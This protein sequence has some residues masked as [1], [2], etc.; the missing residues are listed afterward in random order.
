MF[1]KRSIAG[2]SL[3]IALSAIVAL[4]T[5]PAISSGVITLVVPFSPSSGPDIVAR[6]LA[7]PLG[8]ELGQTVIVENRTGASGEIGMR[9]VARARADGQTLLV[10]ADPPL[11]VNQFLKR[12]A[13]PEPLKQFAPISEL[14]TGTMALVVNNS[15]NV[16]SVKGFV[17]YAKSHA[18]EINYGSPGIGT[19]QHLTMEFFKIASGIS[20]QHVPFKDAGGATAALLG[21]SV[22]AA[23][24]PIQVALPLSHERVRIIG[25][26]NSQRLASAPDVPTISEQG[27]PGFESYFR[28]GMLAPT[29]TPADLIARYSSV[30]AK[31]V[32]SADVAEKFGRL[33][34]VSLG[35]T[36]SE[37]ASTLAS[38]QNKWKKVVSDAKIAPED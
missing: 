22:S 32:R 30:V 23:F 13:T 24:L 27:Y 38:D 25:V 2:C 20:L 29:G 37:Y 11:T 36:P 3:T 34:M 9:Y 18:S 31:L 16:D 14:A 6:S 12:Q 1:S 8:N 21:G 5:R 10:A 26:S 28:V 35:S 17:E 33:G 19:P 15:L 4:A 7:E